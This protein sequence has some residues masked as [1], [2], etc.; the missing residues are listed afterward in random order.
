[1]VF[2]I[3]GATDIITQSFIMPK[4]LMKLKEA[5]IAVLGMVSEIIAYGLIAASGIF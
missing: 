2:S 3:I 4:L 5:R 1:M